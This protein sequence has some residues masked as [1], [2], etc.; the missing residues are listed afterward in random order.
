MSAQMQ[1][2]L[3]REVFTTSR[4]L[5]YFSESELVTQTG[6]DKEDWFPRV[7]V[8]ELVDNSLDDSEKAGIAPEIMVSLAAGELIV[9]DNG[10]ELP[11]V[12]LKRILD[13][14]SRTSDK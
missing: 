12:V 7:L 3:M 11:R 4:E 8:K 14:S 6:Y 2:T 9:E 10:R 5:E 1:P 13:F